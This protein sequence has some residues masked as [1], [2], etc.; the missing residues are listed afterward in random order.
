MQK[1]LR[2][3][4]REVY[5]CLNANARIDARMYSTFTC[6]SSA[7]DLPCINLLS[8]SRAASGTFIGT[9]CPAFSTSRNVK[10]LFAVCM[11]QYTRYALSSNTARCDQAELRN[12]AVVLAVMAIDADMLAVIALIML[13][14]L[15]KPRLSEAVLFSKPP[16]LKHMQH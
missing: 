1:V 4:Y 15:Y 12:S 3:A 6:G 8:I 10:P 13:C 11:H 9:M 16:A 14:T 7:K 5:D 2:K